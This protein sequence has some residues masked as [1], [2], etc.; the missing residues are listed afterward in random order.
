MA[1]TLCFVQ[2]KEP[3]QFYREHPPLY[4]DSLQKQV[5]FQG[6]PVNLT[7]RLNNYLSPREVA[8]PTYGWFGTPDYASSFVGYAKDNTT[9][10]MEA[11][12][13]VGTI[14]FNAG[15]YKPEG[16]LDE[17]Y[18]RVQA[19]HNGKMYRIS[20]K[21]EP[22][23]VRI[24]SSDN[25]FSDSVVVYRLIISDRIE[26]AEG[27]AVTSDTQGSPD[28]QP[29]HSEKTLPLSKIVEKMRQDDYVVLIPS[30]N[31]TSTGEVRAGGGNVSIAL[32]S[33][34]T[35]VPPEYYKELKN[36][37]HSSS[38][39]TIPLGFKKEK[40]LALIIGGNIVKTIDIETLF[41]KRIPLQFGTA[42]VTIQRAD[43]DIYPSEVSP[44]TDKHKVKVYTIYVWG[45]KLPQ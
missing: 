4:L 15:Y 10:T 30:I 39:Y 42:V 44:N 7:I 36:K 18:P 34:D 21:S 40:K 23:H 3:L 25:F 31:S 32:V 1:S 28:T 43:I 38:G 9:I 29:S 14:I 26:V 22:S 19:I 37:L 27:Q 12:T 33:G 6:K 16:N 2:A 8:S 41:N 45:S 17:S 24:Q 35:I 5:N 20:C 11:K 13:D